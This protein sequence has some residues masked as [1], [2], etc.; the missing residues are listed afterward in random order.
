MTV[1]KPGSRWRSQVC[2]VQVVIVRAPTVDG[3]LCCGGRAMVPVD[4][5][6]AAGGSPLTGADGGT[7]LGKRYVDEGS[8]VEVLCTQAGA[9]SLAIEGTPLALRGAKP[10]PA[11][12]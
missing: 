12:D 10:L 3:E 5:P 9:G 8:G 4:D 6:A 2:T 7:Q 11:S 1:V